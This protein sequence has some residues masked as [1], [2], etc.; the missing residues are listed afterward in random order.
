MRQQNSRTA[1][2]VVYGFPGV[3]EVVA[4]VFLILGQGTTPVLC[5]A[6]VFIGPFYI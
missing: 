2:A 4:G 1:S 5:T 6:L 3:T